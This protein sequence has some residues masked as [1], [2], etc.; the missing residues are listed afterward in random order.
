[1]SYQHH[2][3]FM[4]YAQAHSQCI[5]KIPKSRILRILWQVKQL[6][7]SRLYHLNIQVHQQQMLQHNHICGRVSGMRL[8]TRV[9][10]WLIGCHTST[11]RNTSST[12]TNNSSDRLVAMMK[13]RAAR[14]AGHAWDMMDC[15][16]K[17]CF[18]WRPFCGSV[19][20]SRA[21]SAR[22]TA[23]PGVRGR[24]MTMLA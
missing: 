5:D 4:K 19:D 15:T 24:C 1:M 10:N 23:S 6:L 11:P 14:S 2:L 21:G 9:W 17:N 13:E 8:G 3:H 20:R 22:I 12:A 7:D 18:I 16:M